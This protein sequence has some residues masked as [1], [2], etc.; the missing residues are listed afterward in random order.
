MLTAE[1][2]QCVWSCDGGDVAL[3]SSAVCTAVEADVF[4]VYY[5][6]NL[7]LLAQSLSVCGAATE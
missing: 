7:R 2:Q 6:D 4:I 5:C 3:C 1:N